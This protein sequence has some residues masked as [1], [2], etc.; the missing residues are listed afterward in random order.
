MTELCP[1][2]GRRLGLVPVEIAK[3][4]N[5][6]QCGGSSGFPQGCKAVLM[7]TI[8][9]PSPADFEVRLA[10]EDEMRI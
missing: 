10:T 7:V 9:G 3:V 5:F 6:L 8:A 4:G 2:C 1:K